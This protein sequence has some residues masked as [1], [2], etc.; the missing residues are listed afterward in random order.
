MFE[1]LDKDAKELM[2]LAYQRE[3]QFQIGVNCAK[4]IGGF[5]QNYTK[6]I[7]WLR[8]ASQRGHTRAQVYLSEFYQ[9]G[10]GTHRDEKRA[11]EWCTTAA[12]LKDCVAMYIK[13]KY[14]Y[15][16][17]AEHLPCHYPKEGVVLAMPLD[18]QALYEIYEESIRSM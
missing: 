18:K 2:D 10:I 16:P 9:L 8:S 3:A 1:M 17:S 14:Y 7:G 4:G 15:T 12:R 11:K 6:A 5:A 13:D